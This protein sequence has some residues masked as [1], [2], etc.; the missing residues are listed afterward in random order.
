MKLFSIRALA[1]GAMTVA[2]LSIGAQNAR[3]QDG[4][5]KTFTMVAEKIG[6]TKFWLPSTIIVDQGDKVKLK[7]VNDIDGEPNQHG[8]SIPAYNVTELVTRGTPVMV[9]FTADKP[10][11]FPFICQ[12]HPA[13]IGGQLVV[14]KAN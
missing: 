4:G 8:F 7:L 13:H 14:H 6:N 10:G 9:N 5:T 11:V 2:A 12:V 3:A 1:L